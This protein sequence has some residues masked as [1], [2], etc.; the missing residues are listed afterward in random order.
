[1]NR[2]SDADGTGQASMHTDSEL[3]LAIRVGDERAMARLF[4]LYSRLVYSVSLRVLR[5]PE[6]AED[7]MQEV[8]LQIWRNPTSFT[9]TRGSLAG[10]L[11]V[12]SRNR[13]IDVL[14]K[15][16]P[17]DSIDDLSLASG[18]DLVALAEREQGLNRVREVMKTLTDEQN[19][20]LEMAF[21]CG[22]SHSEIA[23]QT[24]YP[25]GT[26]KTRVRTALQTIEKALK[27]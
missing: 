25:L 3:L 26:V 27:G 12:M 23:E 1:M 13:S 18:Y 11:T 22:C 5:D 9:A 15:R 21:F 7:V 2:L 19:T 20:V 17:T 24:G 14:R 16:R 10:L 4:E 6:A 8:F